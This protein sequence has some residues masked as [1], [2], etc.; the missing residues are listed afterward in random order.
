MRVASKDGTPIEYTR[1]GSGPAVI[2]V[3]GA[4]DDGAENAALVPALATDFTVVNY[5]RRGRGGSGDTPPYAV[6]REIEDLAALIAEAAEPAHLY[7]VSSGGMFALEAA[8][9]G[10]PVARLALYEVPYDPSPGAAPRYDEYR[11]RLAEALGAGRRDEALALFMRL[12]GSSDDDIEGA[13]TS[14]YWSALE[15]LAPTL[16]YDAVLYGPPPAERL[17]TVT[18]PTL[19]ATGG[20]NEFF[21][22]AADAVAALLPSAVRETFG[23]QGHVADPKVVAQALRRF[24][25]C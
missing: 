14:P 8:A 11:E 22:Y 10:L 9:A 5:A 25:L 3:G 19:V 12:A 6:E 18:Q 20:A 7:G 16:A 2:L 24:Y 4:L 17:A 21:G 15:A 23:G 13:R 1:E